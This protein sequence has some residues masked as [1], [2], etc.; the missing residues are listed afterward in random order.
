MDRHKIEYFLDADP[1]CIFL[2]LGEG[3][4]DAHGEKLIQHGGEHHRLDMVVTTAV[5]EAVAEFAGLLEGTE[6]DFDTPA[7]GIEV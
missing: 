4:V 1:S 7:K 5:L 3:E 2:P 6:L